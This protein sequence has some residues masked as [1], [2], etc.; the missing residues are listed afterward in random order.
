[1][2]VEKMQCEDILPVDGAVFSAWAGVPHTWMKRRIM[3][4]HT[5]MAVHQ[6]SRPHGWPT[7][8][9]FAFVEET[10]PTPEPGTALVENIYLSVDP[11]MRQAMDEG[12]QRDRCSPPGLCLA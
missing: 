8:K 2:K 4:T 3:M 11:Y 1:M 10:I 12:W 6:V 9:H 7:A 5:S